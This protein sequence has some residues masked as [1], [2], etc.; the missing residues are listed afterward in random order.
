VLVQYLTR[1][2]SCIV[3]NIRQY[4]NICT[5]RAYTARF[6]VYSRLPPKDPQESNRTNSTFIWS[7]QL[8]GGVL[9]L[10]AVTGTSS[11]II[12]HLLS[13]RPDSVFSLG[14]RSLG[15]RAMAFGS[16]GYRYCN[17]ST[18]RRRFHSER[19]L[20]EHIGLFHGRHTCEACGKRLKKPGPASRLSPSL[21]ARPI[22]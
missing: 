4:A 13:W 21:P 11:V 19:A 22:Q 14:R 17:H 15:V 6:I 20:A 18:Y 3:E 12:N 5:H 8:L 9:I 16:G 1:H 7:T 10:S 2:L